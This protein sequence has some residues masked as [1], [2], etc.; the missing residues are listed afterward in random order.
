VRYVLFARDLEISVVS[1]LDSSRSVEPQR[2]YVG[3][4]RN[5]KCLKTKFHYQRHFIMSS[6][7]VTYLMHRRSVGNVQI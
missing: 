6:K 1:A 2:M 4:S 5:Y 7:F 3:T